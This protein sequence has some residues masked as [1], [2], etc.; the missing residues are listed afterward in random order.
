MRLSFNC[1]LN[2]F[3]FYFSFFYFHFLSF[4]GYGHIRV[5]LLSLF[6]VFY[7]FFLLLEGRVSLPCVASF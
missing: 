3:L 6:R 5:E 7:L 4:Y 1:S 2:L